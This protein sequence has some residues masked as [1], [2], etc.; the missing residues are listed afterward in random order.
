MLKV[1]S[2]VKYI[3]EDTMEDK[4]SGFYP[5][6]GTFGTVVYADEL[7]TFQVKW[8][9]GT[10]GDGIWWCEPESVEEVTE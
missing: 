2:R 9:D 1:G 10:D 6:I 5:P 3:H 4:A 7:D 8:D